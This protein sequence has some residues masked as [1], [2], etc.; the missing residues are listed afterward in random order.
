M[1]HKERISHERQA[2][3]LALAAG[4]PSLLFAAYIPWTG[5]YPPM[6]RWTLGLILAGAVRNRVASPLRTIGAAGD[7]ALSGVM[8]QINAM[9]ATLRSQRLGAMEATTHLRKVMEEIDVD[10]FAFDESQKLKLFNRSAERLLTLPAERA[11]DLPADQ[12]G[13]AGFL[14]GETSRTVQRA[15]PCNS[16]RWGIARS[17]FR[18]GGIPHQLHCRQPRNNYQT[19]PVLR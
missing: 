4:L 1:D 10:I 5:D 8:Q 2:Q 6:V 19:R 15:F 16:G 14:T 17:S 3:L 9:G 11:I 12:L 7:D 13:L 18:E